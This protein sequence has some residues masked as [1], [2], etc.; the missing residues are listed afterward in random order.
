MLAALLYSQGK[1]WNDGE[2]R[3]NLAADAEI[4][5]QS[6]YPLPFPSPPPWQPKTLPPAGKSLTD[7]STAL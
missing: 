7:V 1:F 6:P 3:S 4:E 5:E 2:A